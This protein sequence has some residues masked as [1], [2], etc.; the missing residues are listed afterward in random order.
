MDCLCPNVSKRTIGKEKLD[1]SMLWVK[2]NTPKIKFFLQVVIWKL[3]QKEKWLTML[4]SHYKKP[5]EFLMTTKNGHDMVLK[6]S[7]I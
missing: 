1:F 7:R 5:K 6:K 3:G 4:Y 2:H